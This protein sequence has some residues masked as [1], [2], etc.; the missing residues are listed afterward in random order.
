MSNENNGWDNYSRLV[1]Q[2][3]EGLVKSIDQLR[4]EFQAVKE[5]LTEL[6]DKKPVL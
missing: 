1:L 5:Q 6:D 2:Q 4:D 3:L